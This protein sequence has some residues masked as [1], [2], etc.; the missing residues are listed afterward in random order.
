MEG[1]FFARL[2]QINVNEHVE[3]KG[4]SAT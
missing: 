1:N 3:K 2:N 4:S